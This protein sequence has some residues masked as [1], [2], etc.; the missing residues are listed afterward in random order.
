MRVAPELY[1]KML[2]CGGMERVFEIGKNF[3]NESIDMTHN[4]EFTACEFYMAYAD[5]SDLMTL[6]EDL[7]SQLVLKVCGDYKVKTNVTKE[8][9]T[10]EVVEIDFKP[11]YKRIPI[12]K[13]LEERL[14]VKLPKNLGSEEARKGIDALLVKLGVPCTNPRTTARMLDKLVGTYIEPE[15]K[16]PTF[17]I[18]HPQVMSPLAKWNR[19]DK[20]LTERFE[21][22]VCKFEICN[23]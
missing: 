9:G 3:R 10:M 1:L 18:D 2:V 17:I 23:A 8:D 16:N 21:L 13:G 12:V 15:C 11:P 6:T 14:K 20:D 7:M 4:P 22:F 19:N 5:Y